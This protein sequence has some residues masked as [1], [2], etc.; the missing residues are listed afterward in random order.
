MLRLRSTFRMLQQVNHVAKFSD[1]TKSVDTTYMEIPVYNVDKPQPLES[2]KARL[3]YQS[4][5]RGMLENDLLL[6]TFAKKYLDNFTEEQT[7]M[8]DRLINS[9]SND[10]DLFYWIV[11]KQPTPKEF[12]NEIMDLLKKHAKNENK[13]VLS[14]PP[15]N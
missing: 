15:L 5:K 8:Y 12:D 6:S 2:R 11:E 13:V 7:M 3:H 1:T 4:R 9:P 14:Q 10:W